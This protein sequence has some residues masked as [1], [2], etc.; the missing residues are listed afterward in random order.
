MR[1]YD[2]VFFDGECGLCDRFVRFLLRRDRA[3]RLRFAP[4]QG[5]LARE[6]L[7]PLGGR[8]EDLDTVYLLTRDGR[9]LVRSAAVLFAVAALGGAWRLVAAL[10]LVP[11]PLADLAYRGVARIRRRVFGGPEACRL[12]TPAERERFLERSL[13]G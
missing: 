7:P 2:V 4:L 10:R 12:P 6:A 13:Q 3:G 9:L 5:A 1:P 11:R 8:P